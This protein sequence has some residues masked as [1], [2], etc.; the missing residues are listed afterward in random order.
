MIMLQMPVWIEY[1]PIL[2]AFCAT[3]AH[4]NAAGLFVRIEFESD[5]GFSLVCMVQKLVHNLKLAMYESVVPKKEQPKNELMTFISH[6]Y[7][8]AIMRYDLGS[9]SSSITIFGLNSTGA[10]CPP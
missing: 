7:S 10:E 4:C 9:Q 3:D 1:F 6:I 2:L 5:N 8:T